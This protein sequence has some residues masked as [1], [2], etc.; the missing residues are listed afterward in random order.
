LT[1]C[2]HL[3]ATIDERLVRSPIHSKTCGMPSI[4]SRRATF[5]NHSAEYADIIDRELNGT[6]GYP[7]R[8]TIGELMEAINRLAHELDVAFADLSAVEPGLLIRNLP[9]IRKRSKRD[10]YRLALHA[11]AQFFSTIGTP[12]SIVGQVLELANTLTDLDAGTVRPLLRPSRESNRPQDRSDVWE[13]RAL[14]AVAV[15][16]PAPGFV[17]A[18]LS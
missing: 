6:H 9:Q 18:R 12:K 15:E 14:V 13:A 7:A 5:E 4:T 16:W 11:I 2:R 10:E 1:A 17:D 3:V 8:I